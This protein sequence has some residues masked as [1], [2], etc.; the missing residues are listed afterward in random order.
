MD[1]ICTSRSLGMAILGALGIDSARVVS[2]SLDCDVGEPAR[3]TITRHIPGKHEC[4]LVAEIT[5][6]QLVQEATL[7]VESES[8]SPRARTSLSPADSL[9]SPS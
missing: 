4:Q 9:E 3:I 2:L 8:L 6:Y 7:T 1:D 5:K